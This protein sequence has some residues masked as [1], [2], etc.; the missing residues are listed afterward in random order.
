MRSR[1]LTLLILFA[2]FSLAHA[3]PMIDLGIDTLRQSGFD[4]L[5]GKRVGLLSHPAGVDKYGRPSWLVL[6]KAPQVNLVALF[7]P[8]H[9]IDGKAQANEKVGHATHG[10]TG[11]PAYSLYGEY[12][13]PSPEMLAGLDVLVIDLQDLGVRSYTYISAMK[14]AMAACFEQGIDVMVL[15]RPNPLGGL[16]V[17]GPGL[18]P[19][20]MSYVGEFEV[21][22][23]YGMT[24]GELAVMCKK[25]PGVLGVS[26]DVRRRGRLMV[27]PMKGWHRD[28]LW[29]QTGLKWVATSPAIPDLSAA[30]GYSMTGL[31]AYVGKWGHGVGTQYNFRMIYYPGRSPELVKRVMEAYQIPGLGFQVTE[32]ENASGKKFPGVYLTVTDW[33]RLDPCAISFYMMRLACQ[34]SPENP[35]VN[36]G[37]QR[38]G[39]LI[40][41]GDP[42]WL[43]ELQTRGANARVEMFLERWKQQAEEFQ[44][45]SRAYWLYQ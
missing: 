19:E 6:Q 18:D 1:L 23:V 40:H 29:P 41:M 42:A 3:A 22:Y 32:G 28:M 35:F 5:Q 15:D 27:V 31:G 30:M 37:D 44:R 11:L 36:I 45:Q 25:K 10:P 33:D 4:K 20:W 17:D 24:I 14:Y 7:G 39:F 38:R 2:T 13:K 16:K 9:G 43:E 8:E 12:R 34:W 26:E 21:P